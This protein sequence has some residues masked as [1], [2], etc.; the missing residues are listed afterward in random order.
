MRA[1]QFKW[2]T[3]QKVIIHQSKKCIA[4]ATRSNIVIKHLLSWIN[5]VRTCSMHV[6]WRLFDIF[7][8]KS[9]LISIKHFLQHTTNV[10]ACT[11]ALSKMLYCKDQSELRA[12]S[13]KHKQNIRHYKVARLKWRV[14]NNYICVS[15]IVRG[16]LITML[17]RVFLTMLRRVAGV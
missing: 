16:V 12:Q 15:N 1:V 17:G 11:A 2:N 6:W 5:N 4:P 14:S 7:C 3:V 13:P 10:E 9:V 8:W